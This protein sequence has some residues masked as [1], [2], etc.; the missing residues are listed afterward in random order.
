MMRFV[1][2]V[3]AAICA[4]WVPRLTAWLGSVW[5]ELLLYLG[6]YGLIAVSLDTAMKRYGV[7]DAG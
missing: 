1:P 5:L 3:V 6:V 4:F 7:K 2:G